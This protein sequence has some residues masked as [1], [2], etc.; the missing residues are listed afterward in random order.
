[1]A[2]T[3]SKDS[4]ASTATIGFEATAIPDFGPEHADTFRR[5]LHPDLRADSANP[6]REDLRDMRDTLPGGWLIATNPSN[7]LKKTII[8]RALIEAYLADNDFTFKFD[9][10]YGW[11]SVDTQL[12]A[13]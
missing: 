2:R 10:A 6:D 7:I 9:R 1:M 12:L 5:D 4:N 11:T 8:R 3:K 13:A